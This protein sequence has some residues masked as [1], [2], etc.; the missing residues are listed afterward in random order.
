MK[1]LS[2]LFLVFYVTNLSLA[3]SAGAV[4]KGGLIWNDYLRDDQTIFQRSQAGS[5]LGLEVRLGADDNSYFKLGGYYG[6]LHMQPQDHPKET[7]FF[8]VVDGYNLL[9][10]ICGVEARLVTQRNFNWRLAATGA[11][12]FIT[13]VKGNVL[14]DDL[15]S[16]MFG[17][18]LSTGIDVSIF[19]IDIALEPVLT[20]FLKDVEDTK[21]V[22]MMMTMGFHF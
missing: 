8:K 17:V 2:L 15:S 11:F 20:D 4:I 3:Q 9:K 10:A 5:V 16:G 7:K 13:G 12:S 18:H 19:S 14:I 6:R 21:P 1:N 22:M